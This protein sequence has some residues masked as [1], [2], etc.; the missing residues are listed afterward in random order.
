MKKN[1]SLIIFTILNLLVISI[2]VL[3]LAK[4]NVL[5]FKYLIL[6]TSIL[7]FINIGATMLQKLKH[8]AFKVLSYILF[9]IIFIISIIGI[10]YTKVTLNFMNDS[11]NTIK[12]T[13]KN[14]Y[15][16]VTDKDYNEIYDISGK[17]VG[18]YSIIP[19]IDKSLDKLTSLVDFNKISYN[20]ITELFKDLSKNLN[21]I[22]IEKNIYE[23][24]KDTLSL[25]LNILYEFEI[26]IDEE[27]KSDQIKD[28]TNIYISGLDFNTNSDFN[29]IVTIN[30]N[31]NKVLLTS[32]PRDYYLYMPT[33]GLKDSLE[34]ASAWGVN[35]NKEAL[36]QLFDIDIDYYLQI[37][38]N[39]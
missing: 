33:L 13:Y 32:I 20:N 11:F 36:E 15:Y 28:V 23:S 38:T 14:T 26:T 9:T 7:I 35:T 4:L 29:M 17:N 16:V 39:S 37:N 8:K 34:F 19:N 24:I 1:V 27:V 31:T 12:N 22:V 25:N 21:A 2:L 18:Y 5:P 3:S 6:L 30:R 10:Y